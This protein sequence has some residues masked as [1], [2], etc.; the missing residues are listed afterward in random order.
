[1]SSVPSLTQKVAGK[2]IP[3]EKFVSRRARKFTSQGNRLAL[4]GL[5]AAYVLNC[6]SMSPME[7]LEKKYLEQVSTLLVELEGVKSPTSYGQSADEY[8]DGSFLFL[9][10]F[11]SFEAD[12][13]L[14]PQTTVSP[15]S[16]APSSFATLRTRNRTSRSTGSRRFPLPKPMSSRWF[17]S[18]SFSLGYSSSPDILTVVPPAT[19][20]ST[21]KISPST[22]I[23]FSS[24]VRPFC[25][26]PSLPR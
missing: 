24:P 15:I 13:S 8:W 2:S 20:S 19:Y 5:E 9:P 18:S 26:F 22:T 16:S 10:F 11:S 23:S 21:A 17:P 14:S 25:I 6:L 3:L 1:M 4:A 12:L 7:V